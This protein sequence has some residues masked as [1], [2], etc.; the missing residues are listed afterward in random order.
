[1][2]SVKVSVL[3]YAPVR[4]A[5]VALIVLRELH[6]DRVVGDRAGVGQQVVGLALP[7]T[8][9]SAVP[10]PAALVAAACRADGSENAPLTRWPVAVALGSATDSVASPAVEITLAV[11]DGVVVLRHARA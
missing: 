1:M 5:S 2:L 6:R 8:S 7:P 11:V 4:S 3:L 10:V 9:A